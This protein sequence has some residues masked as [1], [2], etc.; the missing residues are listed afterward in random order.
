MAVTIN[1]LTKFQDRELQRAQ[2]EFDR[3]V[4]R[5]AVQQG[6]LQRRLLETGTRMRRLGDQMATVGQKMTLGFT[7]PVVAGLGYAAR[8]AAEE[9]REM[10]RLAH[11][12]TRA[13]GATQAQ[14]AAT[15]DWIRRTQYATGVADGELRPALAS[16]VAA[17]RDTHRAQELLGV[18]LDI[19]AAKGRPVEQVAGALAKAYLGNVGALGRLG[20]A[21]R[22]AEGK[23]L[24]FKEAVARAK[25]VYGGSA[26]RAADTT[27]GRMAVLRARLQDLAEEIGTTLL[28]W[29]ERG[30][31]VV[32][33]LLAR[34]ER[35]S[36]RTKEWAVKLALVAAAAGPVLVVL[37]KLGGAVGLL[38]QG[39][40]KL[41]AVH[42]ASM[43]APWQ[44]SIGPMRQVFGLMRAGVGPI[45]ALQL[46]FGG[47]AGATLGWGAVIIGVV[48]GL[49][50][51]YMK[52]AWFRRA[53][54][55]VL[56]AI[57]KA[58]GWFAKAVGKVF[59]WIKRHWRG[60]LDA[61]LIA[62]G[63]IGWLIAWVIHHWD[64]CRAA[65]ARIWEAVKRLWDWLWDHF[66]RTP[67]GQIVMRVADAFGRLVGYVR[68]HWQEIVRAVADAVNTIGRLINKAFGWTGIKVPTVSWGYSK[69]GSSR[70][71]KTH[72]AVAARKGDPSDRARQ[73]RTGDAA[74]W[75]ADKLAG[76]VDWLTASA[77]DIA[78]WLLSHLRLPRLPGPLARLLPALVARIAASLR[79]RLGSLAGAGKGAYGWAYALA[80]RFGLTVTSTYRPGAVTAAGYRSDHAVYGRAADLAGP[81]AA[82]ARLWAYLVETAG[83]WKQAI[84][85]HSIVEGGRVGHYAPSDHFDHVHVARRGVGDYSG[86]PRLALA[87][88]GPVE[89]HV[90]VHVHIPGGTAL[91]GEAER[92]AEVLAP[93]VE[94]AV[95]RAGRRRLRGGA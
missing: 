20:V 2:R 57:G 33:G 23:M 78:G 27:A 58:F 73:P 54:H 46:T 37:G 67:V 26:A 49:V 31:S 59:G 50:L 10:A 70:T 61:F 79:R 6:S 91:V 25:E 43:V 89:Q 4:Q 60:L 82:M 15:E 40:G 30:V 7:V 34:F 80:R 51:L 12:L 72:G 22:D 62:T 93:Y 94:R 52:C 36:P 28:P 86:G 77:G 18:A 3:L 63:P 68:E 21:T 55:A 39:L 8:A 19:A 81:P 53:V 48:A 16:L 76:A 92:V 9:Q 32:S 90:H 84:Y 5:A 74:D 56:G 65:L 41:A 83:L 42:Q 95:T 66:R 85:R 64:K 17:T 35:L 75:V 24:S 1:I 69:G 88:A 45:K 87:A 47:L 13:A 44:A 29:L 14:V 38:L 71:G 11:V